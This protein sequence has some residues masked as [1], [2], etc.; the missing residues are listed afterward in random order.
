M[1]GKPAPPLPEAA[2]PELHAFNE[3][4]WRHVEELMFDTAAVLMG[5]GDE[6]VK[7]ALLVGLSQSC[8]DLAQAFANYLE[9]LKPEELHAALPGCVE[10]TVPCGFAS[11]EVHYG[12][13]DWK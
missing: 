8:G 5:Y 4:L 2:N 10:T 13:G 12:K 1:R 7:E 9:T 6:Q 11:C 3:V